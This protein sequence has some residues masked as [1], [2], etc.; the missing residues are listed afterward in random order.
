MTLKKSVLITLVL[1]LMG[2]FGYGLPASALDVRIMVCPKGCGLLVGDL[3]I[4]EQVKNFD[5]DINY[6]PEA[7]G[8]YL[9][10]LNE[11]G[12]NK[13]RW[14]DTV[15]AINDDTLSFGPKGGKHPFAMFIPEPVNETF[16][17]LHGVYWGTTGHFFI[18]LDPSIK[19][20][21]DLKGKTIGLGLTGQSD[22]GMNPTLD[23]E[24]G[25]GITA[26]NTTLLYLGPAKMGQALLSG[27]IDAAVAALGTDVTFTDWLPSAVFREWK[28]SGKKLYYIGHEPGIVE[29]LNEEL[30]TSYV[31]CDIPAGILP[32]QKE[33]IHTF[34]D[35]DFKAVHESFPEDLAYKLVKLVAQVGPQM[36]MTTGLWR[37]WSPEIMV[38]GLSEDNTHPGAIR[39]F[40]ELGWWELRKNF[41]P[42]VLPDGGK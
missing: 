5:P 33:K 6:L 27:E 39:A 34:V 22:W 30:N 16:K 2:V 13:D 9:A 38:A 32:T 37:T 18:T 29:K 4:M 11:M 17:L 10:N 3:Y 26:E 19:S 41:T 7:T 42:S 12:S 15:F 23:L 14:K 35:R 20:V 36:K 25:Y 28:K 31:E 24:L 8:G 1:M 21:S 40:K